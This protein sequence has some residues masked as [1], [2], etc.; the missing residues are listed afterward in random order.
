MVFS[1]EHS[2]VKRNGASNTRIRSRK[3]SSGGVIT[4][5]SKRASKSI[6]LQELNRIPRDGNVFFSSRVPRR[7]LNS[8]RQSENCHLSS[9]REHAIE[10]AKC[11]CSYNIFRRSIRAKFLGGSVISMRNRKSLAS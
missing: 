10:N 2:V 1:F 5:A 3:I 4:H 9:K 11:E 7:D 6:A 8:R